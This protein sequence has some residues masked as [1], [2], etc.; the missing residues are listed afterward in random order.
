MDWYIN[1]P[2][3]SARCYGTGDGSHYLLHPCFRSKVSPN[4]NIRSTTIRGH[5]EKFDQWLLKVSL[6]F[7][8]ED[9]GTLLIIGVEEPSPLTAACV[10]GDL[11]SEC[12]CHD[13]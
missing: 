4:A 5:S 10:K 8:S 6:G 7:V 9:G 3:G 11:E 1:Q 13:N 2:R 12:I